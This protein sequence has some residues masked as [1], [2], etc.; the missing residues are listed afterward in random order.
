[1]ALLNRVHCAMPDL[2]ALLD[3][4]HEI[5]G[6][7]ESRESQVRTLEAQR[8]AENRQQEDRFVKLEEEMV[9][10]SKKHSAERNRLRMEIS[11][12]DKKCKEM[13]GRLTAEEKSKDALEAINEGLRVDRRQLIKKYEEDKAAMIQKLS[14]DR[15]RMITEHRAKQRT[16][17]DELQA[18]NRKAEATLAHQDAHLNRAH[19]EE[20]HRLEAMWT[21]QKREIEDRHEKLHM[22]LEDKLE[23]K[24]KILDE[25]R[26]TY[27]QAREGWDRERET[28]TRRWDEERTIM[29]KA[30]EEQSKAITTRHERERNDILR[31]VSP[32][33]QR[34]DK[35][36]N[37]LKLQK[38]VEMLR[39]GW[40]ADKFRFQR[41]T[42]EFKSTARTLNEHNSKLQRLTE[43]FGDVVEVK[44]K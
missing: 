22:D 32:M 19:E 11:V 27:L 35:E 40:E 12:V 29:R 17:H 34:S 44:G 23:A 38:E 5:C 9:S 1:M 24:Q 25:E 26:R 31:Q 13:Q 28:I 8:A 30:S 3:S 14:L 20:K 6:V 36:D 21:K 43:A 18:H 4:Y 7:L 2:Y 39:S 37:I 10:L 41:T 33:Q 15:D 16:S 42:A